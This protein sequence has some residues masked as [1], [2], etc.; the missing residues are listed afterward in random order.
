[1]HLDIKRELLEMIMKEKGWSKKR[2]AHELGIEYSYFCRILRNERN[3]GSKFFSV[4][5]NFC[6]KYGLSF[7][8][9]VF[10]KLGKESK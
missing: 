6:K 1:M 4:F 5:L 3:P 9:Y 8:E 10:I 2:F 7:D